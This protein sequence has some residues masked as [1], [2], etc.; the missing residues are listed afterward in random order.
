M[1]DTYDNTLFPSNNIKEKI[2]LK[3]NQNSSKIVYNSPHSKKTKFLLSINNIDKCNK[4][5][6]F[7][8][9]NLIKTQLSNKSIRLP[10]L[11][12][13]HTINQNFNKFLSSY[14][15]TNTKYNSSKLNI[16]NKNASKNKLKNIKDQRKFSLND[17][18]S[19]NT[20]NTNKH[21]KL[22]KVDDF[23]KK[24][25][26]IIS[27]NTNL[28]H[29][30]AF[31][32]INDL[33]KKKYI[34]KKTNTIKQN[35]KKK[36][37]EINAAIKSSDFNTLAK[38]YYTLQNKN[39]LY[40]NNLNNNFCKT[41]EVDKVNLNKQLNNKLNFNNNKSSKDKL[42]LVSLKSTVDTSPNITFKKN[43]LKDKT[44]LNYDLISNINSSIINMVQK[45]KSVKYNK[46]NNFIKNLIKSKNN[47][48]S[49]NLE[50]TKLDEEL[51]KKNANELNLNSKKSNKL[52]IITMIKSNKD[53]VFK[54]LGI[55]LDN[56]QYKKLSENS[57]YLKN[58]N[59]S[60][61]R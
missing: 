5:R 21:R 12:K 61:V 57:Y 4:S 34:I 23:E 11:N 27:D 8:I 10:E 17:A 56:T 25:N 47:I 38:K 46:A 6:N 53:S 31:M 9:D 37:N 58:I 13:K 49:N 30:D 42:A 60:Q 15:L 44:S 51:Y 40:S 22:A 39:K 16:L 33:N 26:Y 59:I 7:K 2:N 20:L 32:N 3:E 48:I 14:K 52:N 29:Y 41:I 54:N 24:L 19:V 45:D 36:L 50:A 28:F 1:I 35:S 55:S 43:I 18:H